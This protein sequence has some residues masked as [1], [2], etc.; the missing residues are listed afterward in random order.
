MTPKGGG[1]YEMKFTSTGEVMITVLGKTK[2]G[3]KPQGPPIKFR[4]KPLP[5]PELKIAGTFSPLE[6]KKQMLSTVGALVAGASGFDFQANYVTQEWS[7]YGKVKGKPVVAEGTGPNLTADAKQIFTNCDVGSK[8]V[9]DA[10]VKGPDGK[11]Q[12]ATCG[13]KVTK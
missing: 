8:I 2:D 7:I 4:V 3:N 5:K 1:K 11:T 13:V 12:G 6:L 10:R 9:V